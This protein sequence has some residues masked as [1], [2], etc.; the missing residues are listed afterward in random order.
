LYWA[1]RYADRFGKRAEARQFYTDAARAEPSRVRN[2]VALARLE[3]A[4]LIQ[5]SGEARQPGPAFEK[6]RPLAKTPEELNCVAWY[7]A[8]I[9]RVN[10]ALPFAARAVADAPGCWN[11]RDTMARVLYQKGA[12]ERAI[13]EEKTAIGMLPEGEEEDRKDYSARLRQYE[14]VRH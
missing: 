3:L 5:S 7:L 8:Q 9:G 2:W 11:C 14:G 12:I 13:E 10:E 1:G 4:E 6:L